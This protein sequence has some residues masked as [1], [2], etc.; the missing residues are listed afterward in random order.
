MPT[1]SKPAAICAYSPST[2]SYYGDIVLCGV[3]ESL[4]RFQASAVPNRHAAVIAFLVLGKEFKLLHM[5]RPHAQTSRTGRSAAKIVARIP[6]ETISESVHLTDRRG[7]QNPSTE[8][9]LT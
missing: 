2:W 3:G 4:P 9:T 6:I 1:E 8:T 7:R 5:V